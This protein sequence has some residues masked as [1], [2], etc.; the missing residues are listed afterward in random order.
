MRRVIESVL[1][2]R[3]LVIMLFGMLLLAGAF[4]FSQLNI[5]A[6]PDPVPPFVQIVTLNP[7][8]SAEEIE[9]YITVPIE[10]GLA[11]APYR[12]AMRSIS[13]FGLSD[14]RVQFTYDLNYEE[15]LQKVLNLLSQ[16]PQLQNQAQPSISPWSPIGEIYR[17]Q[18]VGPPNYSVMD[19][20]TLQDWVL[21]RQFKAV[22]GVLDVVSWGGKTKTFEIQVDFNKLIAYGLTLPQV[23]DTLNKSN[24]NVGGQTVNIGMQSAVVRGVGQIRSIDDI[25]NTM[26][27][28]VGGNPV[29]VSDIG[30]VIV[31]HL[32]R[33]GVAGRDKNDDIV[34][35]TVL[36]RRGW[37]STPTIQRVEAEVERVNN[38]DILPPGVRIERIYDRSDLIN[39]TTHTVM[40]NV[41][42][43]IVLVFLVQ[44]LFLGDLRSAIIVS[45]AIPF[46]FSFAIGIMVLRGESANL[47]SVGA[48]DF[49]LIIDATVI[50]V[51]NIFRHLAQAAAKKG[52]DGHAA[53][54]DV[55][56][57]FSGKLAIIFRASIEVQRAI[58]YSALII[59]VGFLPLFTLSGVEGHIFG[60]MAKTYAYALAG[61]L[62]ATFTVAPALS[63]FLLSDRISHADTLAVRI[64]RRLYTPALEFALKSK[65][66]SIAGAVL[67][68]GLAVISGRSLGLE[69]LPTLEEGNM[70]VRATMPT[71]ISI[72]AS[73]ETVNRIRNVIGSY[74][75][76][77]TVVSQQGR[78][79]DGTDSNGFFNAEFNIPLKPV[80]AW[81][82]GVDKATLI[83]EINSKLVEE[84][85]GV[86]FAFSQYLQD[87]VAE[88]I[89]GV[90]GDN[91][92]KIFGHDLATLTETANKIQAVMSTV[93]G[94]ADLAAF[95]VL[96]QPT[97]TIEIDRF[98]AGRYGLAPGDIN[99]AIRAAI[100]GEEAGNVYEPGSDRFFPII[101]RLAPE[102]R[103]NIEAINNLTIGV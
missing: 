16:L 84:F 102:Y 29:R 3:T 86:G 8:Q 74:P 89:S 82:K 34:Q 95:T 32:P 64:M 67:M 43:G 70:W 6:Y 60:P 20:R 51:E 85:P 31:S 24:V 91:S 22:P 2:L 30:N 83:E 28:Q 62:I 61:G 37:Q 101:V 4:A 49:G 72:E 48:I 59:I 52:P 69:F 14:I 96:G 92:V 33:L 27:A 79:D 25:R 41:L 99:T 36:M 7:G 76:V 44:W 98:A 42:F 55:P 53:H 71:S 21:A 1:K 77:Q 81:R 93:P 68:L 78:T 75:E 54:E 63:A 56:A 19:L 45:A 17:Y 10:A 80:G 46:A 88:S 87:N 38:S 58:L 26:L 66:L 50:I 100:G 11:T 23:V 13:L 5:E 12:T 57:G 65:L 97:V 39:V 9:R 103:Q 73:N 15:A 18:V 94:I 35:G 40:F 90:K 47:L